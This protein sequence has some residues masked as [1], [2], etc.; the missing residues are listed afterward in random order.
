[1][2]SQK[3]YQCFKNVNLSVFVV[4]VSIS[5]ELKKQKRLPFLLATFFFI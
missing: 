4:V 1:M 5:S 3:K 2:L